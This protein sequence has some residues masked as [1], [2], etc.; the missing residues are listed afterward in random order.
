MMYYKIINDRQV[1]S[2]CKTIELNGHY[3]SNPTAEM[4]AEAGWQ[5]YVPPVVPPVPQTEPDMFSVMQAVKKIL[6]TETEELSDE[7]A[8]DVA[9]M[10]PTYVSMIGKQVS[11]GERL[12][13]D[14]KLYKVLQPHTVS[15]EWTPDTA[16]SLYVE[17]SIVEWPEWVQP[18]GAQDAYNTGD[19]VTFEGAH[20]IS[21]IDA[22]VYSP[23]A[24]PAGWQVQP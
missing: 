17:V 7:D 22:N 20:Y 9:A 13:W 1:F 6:S 14:G 19:K 4:I 8:L 12:W 11:A 24:Y 15:Q 5:V 10:F 2:D 16:V 23:A 18:T 21:L 3:V